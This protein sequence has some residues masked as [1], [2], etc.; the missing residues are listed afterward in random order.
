MKQIFQILSV[1]VFCALLLS[2]KFYHKYYVSITKIEYSKKDRAIQIISQVFTDDFEDLIQE[3]YDKNVTLNDDNESK[4]TDE[5]IERYYNSKLI[6]K[7]NNKRV[8]YNF[9]GKEYKDDMVF[10]YI[11]I[12][13]VEE[14]NSLS[15]TNK[16]LFDLFP[17]QENIVKTSVFDETNNFILTESQPSRLLNFIKK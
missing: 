8:N 12:E 17:D 3:R 13:N 1:F 11:E 5:Y 9:I 10:S 6:I 7:L 2:S 14:I 15:I 4:M 16:L